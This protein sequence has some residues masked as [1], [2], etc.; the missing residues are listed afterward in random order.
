MLHFHLIASLP[1][2]L[3]FTL[4]SLKGTHLL[5]VTVYFGQKET[6]L[7]LSSMVC[8]LILRCQVFCVFN[9]SFFQDLVV[10]EV[11]QFAANLSA[12]VQ[13]DET[14]IANSSS[15]I[16]AIVDILNN[17]ANVSTVVTENV[18]KVR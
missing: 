18:M 17:I 5:F 16:S 15:T 2:I 10:E 7:H 1:F 12:T 6:S 13:E 3:P 11:P 4:F 9:V 14:E 8:R